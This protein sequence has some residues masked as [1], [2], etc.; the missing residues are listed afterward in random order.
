MEMDNCMFPFIDIAD[1]RQ[2]TMI[3]RIILRSGEES[4]ALVKIT[5]KVQD[6]TI[7]VGNVANGNLLGYCMFSKVYKSCLYFYRLLQTAVL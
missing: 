2:S 3:H 5:P 1:C 4:A 6:Y 7:G